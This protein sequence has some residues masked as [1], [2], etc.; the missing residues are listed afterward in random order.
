VWQVSTFA[1]PSATTFGEYDYTRSGNPTRL[2]LEK[3]ICELEDGHKA[4][5][6]STGMAALSAVTR[7]VRTGQEIILNN[8]SY[9]GTYRLL[10]KVTKTKHG[11]R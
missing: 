7:L 5:A 1:Q 8:D 11:P 6:F 3:Q 2:A 4:F 9:G 10:S